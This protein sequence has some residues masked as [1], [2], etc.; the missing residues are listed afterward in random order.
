MSSVLFHTFSFNQDPDPSSYAARLADPFTSEDQAIQ[1]ADESAAAEIAAGV[2]HAKALLGA[3]GVSI[4][5]VLSTNSAMGRPIVTYVATVTAPAMMV[6]DAGDSAGDA[7]DN[8]VGRLNRRA[9]ITPAHGGYLIP[10]VAFIFGFPFR[11]NSEAL[12][13]ARRI[14]LE[15]E[16]LT[17]ALKLHLPGIVAEKPAPAAAAA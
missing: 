14:A 7:V 5:R 4:V 1:T 11:P 9:A 10:D 15:P 16:Y 17:T 12:G 8:L 3:V 13:I 6:M 2:A